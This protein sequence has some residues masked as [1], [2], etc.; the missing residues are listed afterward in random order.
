MV[1]IDKRNGRWR[2]RWRTPEGESR[3]L[4]FDRKVDAERHLTTVEHRKLVGGYVDPSAGRVTVADDWQTWAE[5]QQWRDSSRRLV[6][7]TTRT[8]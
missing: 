3:S 8:M 7:A 6:R 4:A 5:R 2:A 1:S